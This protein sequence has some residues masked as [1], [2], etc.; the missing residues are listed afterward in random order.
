MFHIISHLGEFKE[1][2]DSYL[3][4]AAK[5]RSGC[6][7]LASFRL[8]PEEN[9]LGTH[10]FYTRKPTIRANRPGFTDVCQ[11]HRDTQ[12]SYMG[13]FQSVSQNNG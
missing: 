7:A 5:C 2:F 12:A 8:K 6:A 11:R 13:A 1:N 9:G 3:L 10:C 4:L